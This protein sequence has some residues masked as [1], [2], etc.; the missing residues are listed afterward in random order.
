VKVVRGFVRFLLLL[1]I[2]LG[3]AIG[4]LYSYNIQPYKGYVDK[5]FRNF[6]E[7]P[8]IGIIGNFSLGF[9]E[10]NGNY[11]ADSYGRAIVLINNSDSTDPTYSDLINFLLK[12]DTDS[13]PNQP[14]VA[15][16]PQ[17]TYS[18]SIEKSIDIQEIKNAVGNLL[19]Y[20]AIP[21]L[22]AD[23]AERLHNNS[24]MA[25]IKCGFVFVELQGFKG[26]YPLDVYNTSDRGLVYI[27]D[28][29]SL[30]NSGMANSDKVVSLQIGQPYVPQS[31]FPGD[32]LY[33]WTS[34]G[35]VDNISTFWDNDW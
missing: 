17:P 1:A 18:G 11:Y 34:Q 6:A 14:A 2:F 4:G 21:R 9:V 26:E 35:V 19:P 16:Q 29:G 27:D 20:P 22:A 33:S 12:D 30:E 13:F 23:F 31:L 8:N 32:N 10:I 28:T 7:D 24:E 5:I 3:F 25:G 15:N